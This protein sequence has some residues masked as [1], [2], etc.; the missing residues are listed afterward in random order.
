MVE[1]EELGVEDE[2]EE[3]E[4]WIS[5]MVE[6]QVPTA[7]TLEEIKQAIKK[8]PMLV[9]LTQDLKTGR[10]SKEVGGTEFKKVFG[11]LT[12]TQGLLLRGDRLVMPKD[13]QARV[14]AAA[15]EGHQGEERTLRYLKGK[16]LVSWNDGDVQ[17]VCADLPPRVYLL[18]AKEQPSSYGA[19]GYTSQAMAG[20]CSQLQGA[21]WRTQGLLFPCLDRFVFKMARDCSDEKYKI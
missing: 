3:G 11:E 5:R 12:H 10:M 13:L 21:D 16:G 8:E 4:I 20:V 1:R 6:A 17:G 2:A 7:V 19:K 9:L 14:I 15:H 18:P